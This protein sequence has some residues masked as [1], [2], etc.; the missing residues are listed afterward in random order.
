MSLKP[1]DAPTIPPFTPLNPPK[2]SVWKREGLK[3]PV[4]L[5]HWRQYFVLSRGP[6]PFASHPLVQQL[7]TPYGIHRARAASVNNRISRIQNT[8][9]FLDAEASAP[10]Y[11]IPD[12]AHRTLSLSRL[13]SAQC[14]PLAWCCLSWFPALC[15]RRRRSSSLRYLPWFPVPRCL[16]LKL[17]VVL[18]C[19]VLKHLVH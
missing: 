11:L 7:Q 17:T 14:R 16:P 15:F 8:F 12:Q 1:Y 19:L 5:I 13:G 6:L 2:Q 4:P 3:C 10:W 18:I 9:H